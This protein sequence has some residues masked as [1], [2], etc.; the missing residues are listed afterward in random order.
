[1]IKRVRGPCTAYAAATISRP[2]LWRNPF[3]GK[4]A[5]IEP[6]VQS[7]AMM[8]EPSRGSNATEYVVLVSLLCDKDMSMGCS[9]LLTMVIDWHD[10]RDCMMQLSASM[11]A[12]SCLSPR[13]LEVPTSV[14]EA[15]RRVLD[16]L[17]T[18]VAIESKTF[19]C[20]EDVGDEG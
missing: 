15:V 19:R 20:K 12:T 8:E 5:N 18:P 1:M 10:V 11:S 4:I 2:V 7:A 9:S 6:T 16:T 17:E 13:R 3:P 14:V